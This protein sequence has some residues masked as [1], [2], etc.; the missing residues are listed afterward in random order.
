[1]PS[2]SDSIVSADLD[3]SYEVDTRVVEGVIE[4]MAQKS[5]KL[6]HI[7]GM[8]TEP[9]IVRIVKVEPNTFAT[10]AHASA[11]HLYEKQGNGINPLFGRH[12]TDTVKL[13][14]LNYQKACRKDKKYRK[15]FA[16]IK[17]RFNL[18]SHTYQTI[19]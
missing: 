5:R 18:D 6:A 10:L 9:F 13:W 12:V 19:N 16:G 4:M 11:R 15:T 8:K 1:M 3:A 2:S 14:V 17:E 7:D